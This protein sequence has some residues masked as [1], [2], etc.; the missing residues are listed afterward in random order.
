MHQLFLKDF[1]VVPLE[2]EI[3]GLSEVFLKVNRLTHNLV[4]GRVAILEASCG[5]L[6]LVLVYG[7][8]I[9]DRGRLGCL[10][11]CLFLAGLA[12]SKALL[13]GAYGPL[14]D[15]VCD[16]ESS[17]AKALIGLET[18]SLFQGRRSCR[19]WLVIKDRLANLLD[20]DDSPIVN[21][22]RMLDSYRRLLRPSR[23]ESVRFPEILLL[24]L[25]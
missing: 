2:R 13:F 17:I 22:E 10:K 24:P 11:V 1:P 3:F 8:T 15:T 18:Q 19:L 14:V 20:L 7:G 4:G 21:S 16:I 5:Q 6:L 25:R 23:Y 9:S 12:L